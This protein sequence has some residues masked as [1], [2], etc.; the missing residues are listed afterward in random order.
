M[1]KNNTQCSIFKK[2]ITPRLK[3]EKKKLSTILT[4]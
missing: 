2:S 4:Q 3:F 1:E